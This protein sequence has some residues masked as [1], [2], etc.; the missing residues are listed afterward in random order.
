MSSAVKNCKDKI[1]NKK[2]VKLRKKQLDSNDKKTSNKNKREVR[3]IKK[4]M[5]SND[6]K[7]LTWKAAA[8]AKEEAAVTDVKNLE[9][10]LGLCTVY[11]LRRSII[12]GR[13]R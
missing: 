5:D 6:K 10:E 9:N 7:A 11:K 1:L 3:F 12:N 2:E 4:Q 8:A 13:M